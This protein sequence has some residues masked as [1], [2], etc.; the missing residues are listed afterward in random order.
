MKRFLAL[1]TIQ[2][3][4]LLKKFIPRENIYVCAIDQLNLINKSSFSIVVNNQE[5]YLSGQHWLALRKNRN[6]NTLE[7]FD[8]FAMDLNFYG[9]RIQQFAKRHHL[10]IVKNNESIQKPTSLLCGYFSVMFL[11]KRSKGMPFE[12][13]L[14]QF[15]DINLA[16]NEKI[17]RHFFK[18][19]T[20]PRFKNCFKKCIELCNMSNKDLSSLCIQRNKKCNKI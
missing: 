14:S 10:K 9:S 2:I 15:S 7:V 11:I 1:S 4:F 20:F 3:R 16:C 8:S 5:Q 12:E 19:V 18:S 6:S 13:F 17:V